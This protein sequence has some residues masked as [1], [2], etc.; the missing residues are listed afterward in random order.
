M[1]IT[2]DSRIVEVFSQDLLK[3]GKDVN[4][5]KDAH[6]YIKELASNPTPDNRYEMAQI[7]SYVIDEGIQERLNYLETIADVK[8]TGFGERA[9]FKIEVDG[10]KAMF[11]AKSA[12]TEK[13]KISNKFVT[14][15]TEEVSIR[16]VI[17]F[18]QLQHGKVDLTKITR[19]AVD[20][21]ELA[22]VKRIQDSVYAAFAAMSTP[23]YASGA[24]ITK[25]AF[26]PILFA[27]NRVGGNASVVGD[28]EALAKFTD[29]SGFNS[30]VPEA[31]AVEH[32]QNGVI[33]KYNGSSLLKLN[34]PFQAN[35][36]TDTE[37]RK[38][39]IYV[40]PNADEALKPVKVQLEGG[41]QAID[42]G[43]NINSKETEFRFDKYV[44]VGVIG[45]RK[46]L[47]VYEDTSLA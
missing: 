34:N 33:G 39:L 40:V 31:L 30:S 5:I 6:E 8:E 16:P 18:L 22:I 37:L 29:L 42:G 4:E 32:N 20:K 1:N 25:G 10:L 36:L 47:G 17:D 27:M 12:S 46:L 7:M 28:T 2:K 38:D 14:L 15:D 9:Q 13:S 11:Q 44:G 41:V 35:S 23:N 24:G 21:M 3:K 45:T 19:Q 43:V 26:D